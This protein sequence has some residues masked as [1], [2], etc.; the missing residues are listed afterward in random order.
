[1]I[2]V[3]IAL[4]FLSQ[5]FKSHTKL[6]DKINLLGTYVVINFQIIFLTVLEQ[7]LNTLADLIF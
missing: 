1:M 2:I 5:S 4:R 7:N 6:L 3:F